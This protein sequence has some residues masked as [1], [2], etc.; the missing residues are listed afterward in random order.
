MKKQFLRFLTIGSVITAFAFVSC[1]SDDGSIVDK[2][3]ELP[4]GERWITVAGS[5]QGETPGDGNG[6]TMIYSVSESEA[7]NPE[8]EI[9]VFQDGFNVRSQRTARLQI[10]ED[11]NTLFNIAYGGDNGGEFSTYRVEGGNNYVEFGSKV[12]IAEYAGTAPRWEK[13]FDGDKTGIATSIS[14][15]LPNEGDYQYT[16]GEATILALDLQNAMIRDYVRFEIPLTAEEE[17]EGHHLFR[18]DSPVLNKAKNKLI[19]GTWM[20]KTDP[21]TGENDTNPFD[22]LGSKSVVLDYPSLKNPKV[23]TSE[24]A[25][26]DTSGYRTF[27]NFL[28]DDGNIYQATQRDVNGSKI[29]RINQNNEY[30]N[31]YALS[32]DDALGVT[33]SYVESWR[34]AG[35]GIAYVM[36]THNGSAESALSGQS[37]SFLARVDLYNKTAE[38]VDLPYDTDLYL[39]QYQ[40]FTVV[41][42]EVFIAIAP[43]GKNGNI[44]IL[45]SKTGTVTKG[46][47]LINEPGNHFMGIF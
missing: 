22:R 42:D 31:S 12:N 27:N 10:S 13:L 35:N 14:S 6:G 11:G 38:R 23:I 29:L 24:N 41:G 8:R 1:N 19:L 36:Y 9:R 2:K 39:F 16:R 34:Y 32:L 3:E 47:K 18:L 33:G 4:A 28:A 7:R 25:N 15:P 46:A 26:G 43:V 21:A 30:D 20:R 17:I 37:Q 44:Y 45:N 5:K 40:G